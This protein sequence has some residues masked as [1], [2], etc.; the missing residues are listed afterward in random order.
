MQLIA[1]ESSGHGTVIKTA[2]KYIQMRRGEHGE[3]TFKDMTCQHRGGPLMH[4]SE[5]EESVTCPWH[6]RKTRKCRIPY[7]DIPYVQ[8]RG[9]VWVGLQDFQRLIQNV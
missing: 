7:L 5:D 9:A 1:F 2:L 8:N 3:I 4:G 6:G